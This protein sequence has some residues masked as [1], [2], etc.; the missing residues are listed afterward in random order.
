MV[1]RV[2]TRNLPSMWVLQSSIV[3]SCVRGAPATVQ[4]IIVTHL[5]TH[6]DEVLHASIAAV[7]LRTCCIVLKIHHLLY[8]AWQTLHTYICRES[9]WVQAEVY[10][11]L[12]TNAWLLYYINNLH[13][14]AQIRLHSTHATDVHCIAIL[15]TNRV[16]RVTCHPGGSC[17]NV[18][19]LHTHH[20]NCVTLIDTNC[21]NNCYIRR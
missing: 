16:P 9:H 6:L 18:L 1:Y 15:G 8:A 2:C 13:Y 14:W 11:G 5:H 19:A 7:G 10:K 21:E 17:G 3:L 12:A 20:G 4:L